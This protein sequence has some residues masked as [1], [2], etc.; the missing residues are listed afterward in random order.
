MSFEAYKKAEA[1]IHVAAQLICLTGKNLLKK[2]ADDSHTTAWWNIEKQWLIGREFELG[3]VRHAVYI[4]PINFSLGLLQN[5]QVAEH[6]SL[7]GHSY[8]HIIYQW[9]DWLQKAGYKHPLNLQLHY[10]LPDNNDYQFEAFEKPSSKILNQWA[11]NRT[12]ASK[13]LKNLTNSISASSEIL[14]WPHHFDTGTYYQLHKTNGT[15]DRA[16]GAG[17]NPA[18]NM[19]SKPYCYIYAWSKDVNI[20]YTHIPNLENGKWILTDE[21][22]GAVLPLTES[23]NLTTVDIFFKATA[24]FLQEQLKQS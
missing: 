12:L 11:A 20:D 19:V 4:D 3:G 10:K 1:Q 2:Q 13:A 24:A 6:I 8:A 23:Q 7:D 22:K 18:D 9:K 21:W 5:N 17:F 16:I 14:V 15:T